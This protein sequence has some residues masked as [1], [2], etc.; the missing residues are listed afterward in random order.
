MEKYTLLGEEI[1]L[2]KNLN[3]E[4]TLVLTQL[5][6][7]FK[8]RPIIEVATYWEELNHFNDNISGPVKKHIENIIKREIYINMDGEKK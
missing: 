5:N 8:C 6:Y 7:L 4:S 1:E 2:D 3:V